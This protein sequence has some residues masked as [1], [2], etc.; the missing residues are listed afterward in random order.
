MQHT[1][2]RLPERFAGPDGLVLRRFT[3]EDAQALSAAIAQS[4]SHLRPWLAW[5]S[6]EPLG[7]ERRLARIA[8][9]EREWRRGGDAFLGVFLD[10]AIVGGCGLHRRLAPDGLEIGYW[11]HP[12]FTRRG[13]A[14]TVTWLLTD[15]ALSLPAITHVEIHHDKANVASAAVP[16]TLGFELVAETPDAIEAPAEIGIECRWR[17]E[18][19]RWQLTSRSSGHGRAY[20]R[21]SPPTPA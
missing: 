15:T 20:R 17:M 18:R 6:E 19:E 3:A 5:I 10:D 16:R 11:I 1:R 9:F 14:T 12:R 2:T 8:E 7:I 13:L 21:D 4:A